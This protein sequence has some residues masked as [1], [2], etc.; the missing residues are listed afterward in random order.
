MFKMVGWGGMRLLLNDSTNPH[1]KYERSNQINYAYWT[2]RQGYHIVAYVVS[3]E[4]TY[5][6]TL[7]NNV[8]PPIHL[9]FSGMVKRCHQETDSRKQ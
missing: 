9:V 1:I 5:A 2:S 8:R 3:G 7:F 4:L 6:L